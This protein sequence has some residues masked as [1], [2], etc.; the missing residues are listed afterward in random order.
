MFEN[1]VSKI[2]QRQEEKERKIREEKEKLLALSEKELL[3]EILY[4]LRTVKDKIEV[5]ETTVALSNPNLKD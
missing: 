2:Q 5:L 4:E 1:M 3:V